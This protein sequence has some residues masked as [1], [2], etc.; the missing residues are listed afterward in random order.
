MPTISMFYGTLV[1]PDDWAM[2][3]AGEQPHKIAPLR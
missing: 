1:V 2:A 3:V